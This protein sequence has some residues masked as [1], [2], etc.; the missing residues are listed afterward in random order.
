MNS[1]ASKRFLT[2]A[3][4]ILCDGNCLRVLIYLLPGN[5]SI[6]I[7]SS[8]DKLHSFL[9]CLY[10]LSAALTIRLVLEHHQREYTGIFP[11][12]EFPLSLISRT[13]SI[14]PRCRPE[15]WSHQASKKGRD[16]IPLVEITCFQSLLV[17]KQIQ[18]VCF[19][20]HPD[21]KV[22][23]AAGAHSGHP[24]HKW[25]IILLSRLHSLYF[26]LSV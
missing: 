10:K 21:S 12:V 13:L 24:V 20:V 14:P 5:D 1:I 26:F 4:D 22:G 19:C 25:A 18:E 7:L 6:T 15:V 23:V 17:S 8:K 11:L 16:C 2:L 3:T 9:K